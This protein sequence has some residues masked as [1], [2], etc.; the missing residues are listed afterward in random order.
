MT[1]KQETAEPIA[2]ALASGSRRYVELP[3]RCAAEG[4]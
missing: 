4:F 3:I 2:Y 1:S